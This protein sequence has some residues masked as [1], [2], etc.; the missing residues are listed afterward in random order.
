MVVSHLLST[1]KDIKAFGIAVESCSAITVD[2]IFGMIFNRWMAAEI[3][4]ADI[5]KNLAPKER[6]KSDPFMD[7]PMVIC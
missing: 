2:N 6:N 7:K 1:E 4:E 5:V 3:T